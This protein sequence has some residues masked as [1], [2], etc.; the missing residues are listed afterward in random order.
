MYTYIYICINLSIIY[1]LASF[2]THI[3]Y[4]LLQDWSCL[5]LLNRFRFWLLFA[6]VLKQYLQNKSKICIY[7]YICICIYIYMYMWIYIYMF[8]LGSLWGAR[9]WIKM[10][11]YIYIYT[12]SCFIFFA[13]VRF[14]IRI[15]DFIQFFFVFWSKNKKTKKQKKS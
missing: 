15:Y 11:I 2:L 1:S 6:L 9:F 7:I 12:L 3:L 13:F 4:N 8:E 10:F 5:L 14:W